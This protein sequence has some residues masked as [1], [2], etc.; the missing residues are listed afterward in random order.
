MHQKLK[1]NQI[2]W[3]KLLAISMFCIICLNLI[4][5]HLITYITLR[6]R[7]QIKGLSVNA[8][9]DFAITICNFTNEAKGTISQ[10]FPINRMR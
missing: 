2:Y 5:F 4:S 7:K 8:P 3:L 10:I 1:L 6:Y 9:K